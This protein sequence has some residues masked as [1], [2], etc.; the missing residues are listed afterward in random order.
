MVNNLYALMPSSVDSGE[1]CN[2]VHAIPTASKVHAEYILITVMTSFNP[3]ARF[4]TLSESIYASGLVSASS[5]DPTTTLYSA[6]K[7]THI[8]VG[9]Y[10]CVRSLNLAALTAADPEQRLVCQ[11]L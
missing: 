3:N 1:V 5:S 4:I 2:L 6:V 9:M 7:V 8:K 11:K 10:G